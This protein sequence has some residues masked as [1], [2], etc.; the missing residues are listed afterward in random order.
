MNIFK[1]DQF[2][3][4]IVGSGPGGGSVANE[5]SKREW[6]TLIL[7]KGCGEP[8]KGTATQAV[9]MATLPGKNLH[10]T[11]QMVGLMHGTT[12]G[13]S[14]VFYYACAFDPPYEMFQTYGID[15]RPEVD[16]AKQELPVAPLSDDLIGPAA[17]RIMDSAKDLGYAWNKIPKIVYQS[18]CRPNCDKCVMG[19]P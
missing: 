5:L 7:E 14:S 16:E 6:K 17:G 2:D 19:C 15:L 1:N 18:K 11:Q 3:V 12:V 13:A 4:I 8:I 9:S 10:F